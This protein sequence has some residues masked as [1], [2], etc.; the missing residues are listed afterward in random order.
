MIIL[1]SIVFIILSLLISK[2][3]CNRS[4]SAVSLFTVTWAVSL[5]ISSIDMLG[6][7]RPSI[8]VYIISFIAIA[9]FNLMAILTGTYKNLSKNN[10]ID[11]KFNYFYL[12]ILHCVA[13]IF[14]VPYLITAIK[15]LISNGFIALR[16]ADLSV[17]GQN[18]YIA[19]A[20]Q[21]ICLPL[22]TVAIIV[23]AIDLALNRRNKGLM[24]LAIIDVLIYMLTYGG[25]YIVV[26][27]A[28]YIL[29]AMLMLSHDRLLKNIKKYWKQFVLI[30]LAIVIVQYVTSERTLS[31]F[32][33]GGNIVAYFTGSL[34][35]F[36]EQLK[37]HNGVE[38]LGFG[39]MTFGFII[40][41]VKVLLKIFFGIEYTGSDTVYAE[42]TANYLKIGSITWYNSLSTVLYSF[43]LDYGIYFFWIGI[44]V[45]AI[46]SYYIEK[47]YYQ[48]NNV[49][50]MSIYLYI[51]FILFDSILTNDL[52]YPGAFMTFFIIWFV[53]KPNRIKLTIKK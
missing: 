27:F 14:A 44:V 32:S 49:R 24:I 6:L 51:M 8:I 20:F 53:T 15:Y 2:K 40:N 42:F 26:K 18:T 30:C 12:Y 11:G 37:N 1:L 23:A 29:V 13:Y 4:F 43:V 9:I 33:F 46:F 17:M 48:N 39:A 38:Y 16:A 25:R 45:L 34:R 52:L 21:W 36:S 22:F 5:G 47:K 50:S 28:F 19:L 31:G 7:Y 10:N 3:K 41:M 35:F